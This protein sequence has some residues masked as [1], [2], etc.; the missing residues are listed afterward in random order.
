M[1]SSLFQVASVKVHFF[2]IFLKGPW[3][4]PHGKFITENTET[5]MFLYSVTRFLSHIHT[6]I[7][8]LT[9]SLKQCIL[10]HAATLTHTMSSAQ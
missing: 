4:I 2:F 5:Y 9:F 8:L 3:G 1:L 10:I 6:F 7:P